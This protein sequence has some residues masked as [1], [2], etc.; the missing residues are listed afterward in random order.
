ML[1]KRTKQYIIVR[2]FGE[3]IIAKSNVY[4]FSL[5]ASKLIHSYSSQRKQRTELGHSY[6][7]YDKILFGVLQGSILGP[8]SLN[9]FLSDFSLILEGV[10]IDKPMIVPYVIVPY[11]GESIGN[12]I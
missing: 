8:V 5:S 12:L 9:I 3:L 7:F 11:A 1:E 2:Y 4:G 6:N 10:D